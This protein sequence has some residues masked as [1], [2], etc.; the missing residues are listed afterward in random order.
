LLFRHGAGA[1]QARGAWDGWLAHP[2]GQAVDE[3]RRVL[4]EKGIDLVSIDPL[5]R[6]HE[7]N[8]NDNA[9]MD[10]V[11]SLLI[12]VA[13]DRGCAVDFVAHA[14]KGMN[15]PGDSSRLRGASALRDGARLLY[16]LT[17]MSSK[18]AKRFGLSESERRRLVRL[19]SAKVNFLPPA[20]RTVW[21]RLVDVELKNGTDE[22]ESDRVQTVER[23]HP[24]G[25]SGDLDPHRLST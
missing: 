15:E 3:L 23:W 11:C 12:R 7:A 6:A 19:D 4:L 8:E 17:G 5:L 13:L 10:A 2:A 16:T 20:T 21:F 25:E 22:Y 18:E 24:P 14:S 9:Q 1:V